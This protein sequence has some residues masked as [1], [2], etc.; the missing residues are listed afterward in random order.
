[1]SKPKKKNDL[2]VINNPALEI[3]MMQLE[4]LK[5]MASQGLLTLEE[6]KQYDLLCKNL[7]L[8]NGDPTSIEANYKKLDTEDETVLIDIIKQGKP[9]EEND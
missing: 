4:R 6:T 2:I 8:L 1:M 3:A 7:N 5:V 9:K